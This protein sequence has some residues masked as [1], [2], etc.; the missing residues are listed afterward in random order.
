MKGG[1]GRMLWAALRFAAAF[2]VVL[3]AAAAATR[4]LA[5][6]TK[7]LQRSAFAVLGGL[8]LGGSRQV[9]AV[10]VGRRVLVLGLADKQ[11]QLLETITDPEEIAML[12]APPPEAGAG[13]AGRALFAML[14]AGGRGSGDAP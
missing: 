4:W 7:G 13:R 11:I 12:Q 3:V 14:R 2:V 10:R 1:G 6:Q 9:L 8:A 5:A